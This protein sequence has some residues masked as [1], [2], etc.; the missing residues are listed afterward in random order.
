LRRDHRSH[1]CERTPGRAPRVLPGSGGPEHTTRPLGAAHGRHKGV[2]RPDL[3]CE[4]CHGEL[5]QHRRSPRA[6]DRPAAASWPAV[7]YFLLDDRLPARGKPRSARAGGD[8][9]L[10]VARRDPAR[11]CNGDHPPCV[12]V[13][14]RR[15]DA[16]GPQARPGCDIGGRELDHGP[17]GTSLISR[18]EKGD[19]P[20]G[21]AGLTA[22]EERQFILGRD[23]VVRPQ[24]LPDSLNTHSDRSPARRWPPSVR[25]VG[26]GTHW[27]TIASRAKPEYMRR[28]RTAT[29]G[30]PLAAY[31][32]ALFRTVTV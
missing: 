9:R 7:G 28:I 18:G 1:V 29:Y 5:S 15:H 8:F 14:G 22:V 19:I 13:A 23:N 32:N 4:V 24:G 26:S 3:D 17:S 25:R 2:F 27:R 10:R 31:I 12:R 16:L 20:R 30:R 11:P 6:D 21:G